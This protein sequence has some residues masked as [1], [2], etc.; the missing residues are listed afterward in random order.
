MGQRRSRKACSYCSNAKVRCDG[1]LPSCSKCLYRG[2]QCFYHCPTSRDASLIKPDLQSFQSPAQ[3]V[4]ILLEKPPVQHIENQAVNCEID[5]NSNGFEWDSQNMFDFN[6]PLTQGPVLLNGDRNT[7][8]GTLPDNFIAG[9]FSRSGRSSIPGPFNFEASSRLPSSPSLLKTLLS[10]G[11]QNT[12]TIPSISSILSSHHTIS[13]FTPQKSTI[14]EGSQGNAV[15]LMQILTSYPKMMLR[16]PTFPPFIHPHCSVTAA[17]QTGQLI[18]PLANC[19]SMA[20]LF[21]N[22]EGGSRRILWRMIRMELQRLVQDVSFLI[23]FSN[24]VNFGF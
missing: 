24:E 16:K 7:S 4:K 2:S 19:M 5:C 20:Q 11:C 13:S 14:K 6:Y 21:F 18:E 1:Q 15:L 10:P 23:W 3:S 22:S 12:K 8:S 17:T 9:S